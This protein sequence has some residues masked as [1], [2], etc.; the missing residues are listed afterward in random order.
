MNLG[1]MIDQIPVEPDDA[2]VAENATVPDVMA[3]VEPDDA[4]L[5]ID[6][7][8][9]D[10]DLDRAAARGYQIFNAYKDFREAE[11]EPIWNACYR[12]KKGLA[13]LSNGP[14]KKT[15]VVREIF[16]QLETLKPQ[17]AKAFFGGENLFKYVA[18]QQGFEQDGEAATSI[19]HQQIKRGRLEMELHDFLG[20]KVELGTAYMTYGWRKFKH[21]IRKIRKMHAPNETAWWDRE[22]D[23]QVSE[24]PYIENIPP[25]EMYCHPYV[26]D[27]R[28]APACFRRQTVSK[29]DL[30]TL[31]R[32][33]YIDADKTREAC[34]CNGSGSNVND[35]R[36][37]GL[38]RD[39][40]QFDELEGFDE[41]TDVEM[42][43]MWSNS[44]WEYVILNGT[45]CV[46]AKRRSEP[47]IP[48]I[49]DRNYPEPG[50]HYG[51]PEALLILE[52]QKI[53][54]DFWSMFYD[55]THYTLNPMMKVLRKAAKDYSN[56]RF[57]P[58]GMILLDDLNDVQPLLTQPVAQNIVQ[59]AQ[60][61]RGNMKI[62]TG[63][64]D[65]LS[66]ASQQRT[67]TGVVRLQDA[68]GER[69][70]YKIVLSM[71]AFSD[72]Y[73]QLYNLNAR[74]LNEEVEVRMEG[75]GQQVFARYGPEVFGAD[76]DV[77]TEL[78]NTLESS[79]EAA[80][81]WAMAIKMVGMDPLVDRQQLLVSYFRAIGVKRPKKLLASSI[82]Q[83]SDALEENQQMLTSGILMDPR[84][85][86][87]HAMHAQ[88]HMLQMHDPVFQ[89]LPEQW[90]TEAMRHLQTH[91]AYVQAQSQQN[92]QM[93]QA[94][95]QGPS[96][97]IAPEADAR[98]EAMFG[99]AMTGAQQQGELPG[100]MQ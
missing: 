87:N 24:G 39:V 21:N 12:A 83:Q 47:D 99:N 61:V 22:T 34:E 23:E 27:P 96:Q 79:P 88:I 25:W 9:G 30:K 19:V 75:A 50:F 48:I 90:K 64:T 43:T 86:D 60:D 98:T 93:Q 53:L 6:P 32:E 81:K 17:L 82:T 11:I 33:G 29:D 38:P 44:G 15:Y 92:A 52:D 37:S 7:E 49:T 14:Y 28:L 18:Q 80:S 56:T 100:S 85:T 89:S 94:S 66:G 26:V 31:I 84:P 74:F 40:P 68:A 46:R 42:L 54:N 5:P 16:R 78:A 8:L 45:H 13:P 95:M 51:T 70:D 36:Q 57:Q 62:A 63:I 65:E 59:A 76:I 4:D 35:A 2:T 67:A 72:I 20:T 3:E 73:R 69:I 58:G 10:D 1:A 77:D 97:S 91:L 41:D 71:P 55:V